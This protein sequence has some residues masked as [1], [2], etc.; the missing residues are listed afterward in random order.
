[1]ANWVITKTI[2]NKALKSDGIE[3][4]IPLTSFRMAGNALIVLRGLKILK[5]LSGLSET[6]GIGVSSK[7]PKITTMKSIQFQKS[8]R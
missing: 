4:I 1:M 6:D 3:E 8:L 5:A 7:I 2:K